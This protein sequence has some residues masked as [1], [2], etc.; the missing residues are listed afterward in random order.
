MGERGM[1]GTLVRSSLIALWL[2]LPVWFSALIPSSAT[3]D[4]IY[5]Y[6]G[7][8]LTN[9]TPMMC[10]GAAAPSSCVLYSPTD[11]ISGDVVYSSPAAANAGEAPLSFNFTDGISTITNNTIAQS[12]GSIE[13]FSISTNSSGAITRGA[14]GLYAQVT[15]P[16]LIGA[17]TYGS[18]LFTFGVARDFS[19]YSLQSSV[20]GECCFA[21]AAN[22]LTEGM[23]TG[24]I[25]ESSGFPTSAACVEDVNS[26]RFP[27]PTTSMPSLSPE[28]S[29]RNTVITAI[30][31]PTVGLAK[32]EADCGVTSFNWQQK[33]TATSP[34]P[35]YSCDDTGCSTQTQVVP[36][37][38]YYDPPINGWDYC[39]TSS[40]QWYIPGVLGG[41]LGCANNYPYYF[42]PA[43]AGENPTFMDSPADPCLLNPDGSPSIAWQTDYTYNNKNKVKVKERCN[44]ASPSAGELD[45]TTTLVGIITPN[46]Y[47]LLPYSFEWTDTFNDALTGMDGMG[48]IQYISTPGTEIPVDPSTGFGGITVVSVNGVP[49]PEPSSFLILTISSVGLLL[50]AW[51]SKGCTILDG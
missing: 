25:T 41:S 4:V 47:A 5:Y 43:T 33:L 38:R 3:A 13:N 29:P 22:S 48:G 34:A 9:I 45:F 18:A 1:R 17:T 8:P 51:L 50:T 46:V 7:T 16:G 40:D 23:W 37:T 35:Y 32:T 10:P 28:G 12:I 36:G 15:S 11:F 6:T 27:F 42:N 20:T 2:G 49:V 39:N 31:D 14:V 44:V 21:A 24:P 19:E 26:N 30:F